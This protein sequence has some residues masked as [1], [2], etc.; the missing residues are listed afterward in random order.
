MTIAPGAPPPRLS[1]HRSAKLKARSKLITPTK[2][3][4]SERRAKRISQVDLFEHF[5]VA[6]DLEEE[7]RE[8][9]R[10][11]AENE[12]LRALADSE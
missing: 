9:E 6:K 11:R 1:K 2:G 12:R 4:A 8:N 10:L 5:Q 7:R 3:A